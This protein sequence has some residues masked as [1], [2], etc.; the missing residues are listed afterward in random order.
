MFLSVISHCHE[1]A[2]LLL[3][4]Y[5]LMAIEP[6]FRENIGAI[7]ETWAFSLF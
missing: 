6:T 5:I 7:F 2:G 3:S 4:K 1:I